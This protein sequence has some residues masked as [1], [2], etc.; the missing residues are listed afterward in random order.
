MIDPVVL[1]IDALCGAIRERYR[2]TYGSLKP[3]LPDI[4]AWAT[5]M[6]L[7]NIGNG[8]GLYHDVEHTTNVC[9]VGLDILHGRHLRDGGVS[10]EDWLHFVVSLLCHDIGYVRGLCPGDGDGVYATGHGMSTIKLGTGITDASMAPYHIERGKMIIRARFGET[11]VLDAEQLCANIERTRF[12]VP[13]DGDHAATNDYPGLVRAADLIGQLADPR[14]MNKVPALYCEL[15]ETG[16][17]LALG[18]NDPDD[19]RRGYPAFF[20]KMVSPYIGD[21]LRYLRVTRSGRQWIANLYANVFM[22]EHDVVDHGGLVMSL[23]P[24]LVPPPY[25]EEGN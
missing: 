5:T 15:D 8:D 24:G 1:Q 20:W 25:L 18:F 6:A 17:A 14:Y 21:G 12:P 11:P 7:E 10:P 2:R 3:H 16:A 9:L 22:V 19:V 13:A 23:G 4:A